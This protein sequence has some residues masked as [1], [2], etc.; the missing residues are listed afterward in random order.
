[1]TSRGL[2]STAQT[3]QACPR[4][5]NFEGLLQLKPLTLDQKACSRRRTDESNIV[6]TRQHGPL[7]LGGDA[8]DVSHTRLYERSIGMGTLTYLVPI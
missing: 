4:K 6:T 1:M 8:T 7:V 5:T 2:S 3:Q